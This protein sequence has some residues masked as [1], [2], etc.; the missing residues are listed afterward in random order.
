MFQT[1]LFVIFTRKRSFAPSCALLRS[2]ALFFL[3]SFVARK[4]SLNGFW[5]RR[6]VFLNLLAVWDVSLAGI[7]EFEAEDVVEAKDW[8]R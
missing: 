4:K 5:S 2:F 3:R 8:N 6:S 1:W 7:T